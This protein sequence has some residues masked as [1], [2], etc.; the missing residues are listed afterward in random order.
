MS[1]LTTETTQSTILNFVI[2]KFPSYQTKN[3]SLT[4]SLIGSSVI[5]SFA[6]IDL[7]DMVE[8]EFGITVQDVDLL[9]ENFDSVAAITAFVEQK[10]S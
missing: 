4:D 10:K 5:D 9:P 1:E 2:D 6:I 7:V 8:T 3:L